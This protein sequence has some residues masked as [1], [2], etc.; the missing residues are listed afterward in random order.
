MGEW[1]RLHAPRMRA[2]AHL[3]EVVVENRGPDDRAPRLGLDGDIQPREARA[4]A[5]RHLGEVIVERVHARPP[6]GVRR[7]VLVMVLLVELG[8]SDKHQVVGKSK[9]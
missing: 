6:Q 8:S 2:R 5:A 3:E 7:R 1:A 4:A 9:E